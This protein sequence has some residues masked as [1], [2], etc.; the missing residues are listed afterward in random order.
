MEKIFAIGDIHGTYNKL[1]ALM[2][3]IDIDPESD[4]LVFVGDYID[5]GPDSFEVVEYLIDL[6]K[7]CRNTVFLKGNHE[8]MLE[9]YIYG[10]DKYTYLVNGGRK[11][12]E[13]YMKQ[14][15]VSAPP[16]PG[17][18]LDFFE[19]LVL[20]YETDSYIFVHAGL[21]ENIPL[22]MQE[23]DDLLWIRTE[24]IQSDYDF[25]KQV[26]FGHTPF[27][28]PLV[29]LNKI[30]IDTGAVYGN[31]LTCVKLPDVEFYSV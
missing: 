26:I 18:H 6:K 17:D 22:E 10:P 28:E 8:D 24:F 21:R 3:K 20:F 11:T 31:E 29:N 2:D 7:H 1:A 13:S 27:L 12:L 16:I 15:S 23:P 25:G 14:T 9:K 30:G 4:T 19:S 5:R